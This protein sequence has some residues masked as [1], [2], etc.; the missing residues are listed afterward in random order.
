MDG[1]HSLKD[2]VVILATNRPDLIDPA[3][4]RPGRIDRKIKI[5]RPNRKGCEDILKIYLNGKQEHSDIKKMTE[6]FL[7]KLFAKT[8]GQEVLIMT[9]K[10]GETRPLYWKDFISGAIIEGVVQRAKEMA[11]ERAIA[12]GELLIKTD[13]LL[14]SLETEFTEGSLLPA[15]PNLEDWLQLLDI[16]PHNVVWVRRPRDSDNAAAETFRRSMI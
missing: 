12:G 2:T 9:L 10:T 5:S 4:L 15:Q 16:D 7:N 14:Q 8:S 13:D 3:I 11:I 6:P 1:I